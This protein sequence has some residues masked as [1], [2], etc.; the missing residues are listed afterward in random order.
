MKEIRNNGRVRTLFVSGFALALL[1]TSSLAADVDPAAPSWTG[2]YFGVGGGGAFNSS[3]TDAAGYSA[4]DMNDDGDD[5]NDNGFGIDDGFDNGELDDGATGYELTDGGTKFGAFT[6]MCDADVGCAAE[7][8]SY[9]IMGNGSVPSGIFDEVNEILN[10]GSGRD[11]GGEND[12]GTTS[13]FATAETGFDYQIG[14]QFLI[15]LNASFDLGEA[16]VKNSAAGGADVDLYANDDGDYLDAD[17]DN[18]AELST[19][20]EFGNSYSLGGRAGFLLNDSNLLFASGGFVSTKASLKANYSHTSS[21]DADEDDED[22][23]LQTQF[24]V[25]SSDDE[26]MNG[27]YVGGGLESM[28]TDNMSFKLEYRFA[29]LGSIET[30]QDYS[31]SFNAE[32]DGDF[33]TG[34]AEAGVS[35]KAN[36]LVHSVRATIN[37]RF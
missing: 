27:Y 31:T 1:G 15:G 17:S 5:I 29:D 6:A 23:E 13:A 24:D 20:L 3:E 35:A 18:V 26:W 28:F 22:V 10:G 8:E 12:T 11:T 33:A 36:P 2:F 25:E 32:D 4:I 21:S 19:E 34:D 16:S 37:W 7:M 30:S 9:A 14:N